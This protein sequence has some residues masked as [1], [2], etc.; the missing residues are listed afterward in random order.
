MHRGPSILLLAGEASGDY[1][2][3]AL[4]REVRKLRPETRFVGIG[5][6]KLAAEG[7]ELLFHY[8][9]VNTIG[10]SEGFAKMRSIYQA[11]QSMKD[12]LRNGG[13]QL[14]IPVDYPDVNIRL[15]LFAKRA[16]IPVCY[17]I[18]PQVWAWRKGRTRKLVNRVNRM[19]TLFPF[20]EKLYRNAGLQADFVG[21]TMVNDIPENLNRASVRS[22]LNL[23]PDKY[24]VALVPGS[25]PAEIIR[26][27]PKMCEAADSFTREFPDTS[28]VLPLAGPHL[29]DLVNQILAKHASEIHVHRT[30]ASALMAAA[31]CGLVTSGTATLQA[32]LAGMPHVV[33]YELDSLSWWF[34]I[35]I[36]RPLLMDKDLHVA[37]ANVLAIKEE[38]EG[39]GPIR[40]M[41]DAGFHVPCQECRRPLFVPE[42][43]QDHATASNM[44]DWLKRFRTEPSL[45][46]AM[47]RGFSDLR[48]SLE[49]TRTGPTAAE[50]VSAFL[51]T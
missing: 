25:R 49:P 27:L 30:E 38:K 39:K 21:H 19:M 26:M 7:M 46:A 17:Y 11:Y 48:R 43:L 34:A 20:E 1:H 15:C 35:K 45:C 24:T 3:A 18:S 13:H 23:D 29:A 16:G 28:F 33:A 41:L 51:V 37:I 47:A 4:V 42:L 31:D 50:I 8:K 5:G 12:Q 2:A 6:D 36:L 22:E 9:D 10:L 32:A 40:I 14:F 44:S